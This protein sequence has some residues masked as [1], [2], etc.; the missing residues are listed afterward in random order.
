MALTGFKVDDGGKTVSVAGEERVEVLHGRCP[1][2]SL[3]MARGRMG[4]TQNY[5]ELM[6]LFGF[7]FTFAWGTELDHTLGL[8]SGTWGGALL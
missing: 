6:E 3:L 5:P 1:L 4:K 2:L 7:S 8:R